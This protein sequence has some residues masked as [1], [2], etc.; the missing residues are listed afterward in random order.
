MA[1]YA[2]HNDIHKLFSTLLDM[3][4][5]PSEGSGYIFI[6]G[7]VLY[8]VHHLRNKKFGIN[9][10]Q[11]VYLMFKGNLLFRVPFSKWTRWSQMSNLGTSVPMN[12]FLCPDFGTFVIENAFPCIYKSSFLRIRG[13]VIRCLCSE[14]GLVE[15]LIPFWVYKEQVFLIYSYYT[16][17]VKEEI[18]I[19]L[20]PNNINRDSGIEIPEAWM[21]T[22]KKHNNRRAV[23]QRTTEGANHWVNSK[24][25][26]APIRAVK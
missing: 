11:K 5:A 16:S 12:V 22:I 13:T 17:R 21:P 1:K 15:H 8:S 3:D 7:T 24:G 19:R 25:R 2:I 14:L 20:H 4:R 9:K 23:R 10:K 26:N 18:H 6:I